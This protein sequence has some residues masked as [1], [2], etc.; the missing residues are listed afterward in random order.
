MNKTTLTGIL[1]ISLLAMVTMK[2]Y[3]VETADDTGDN[4]K[5]KKDDKHAE[6]DYYL[7]GSHEEDDDDDYDKTE[8]YDT[9]ETD[10]KF[11]F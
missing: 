8:E 6:G 11:Y 4:A 9:N 1:L 10:T 7:V 3:L 2:T 5:V